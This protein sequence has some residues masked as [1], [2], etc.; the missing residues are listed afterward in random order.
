MSVTSKDQPPSLPL[1]EPSTNTTTPSQTPHSHHTLR[2]EAAAFIGEFIGTFM[3]L[4]LAFTGTQIALNAAGSKELSGSGDPLPDVAKLLYIAFAFGASLAINVAIFADIS[5]G[6]FVTI[7]LY[8]TRKIHWHRATQTII[9][10]LLASIAASAFT[11][12]LLPGPL[13]IATTLSPSISLTRGLF[14][15]ALVTSQLILTILML[16]GGWAKPMY[17]GASL[18]VAHVCSVYYTGASLNPARSFGPAVVGG[19]TGYHWIY[20]V[21]PL[22]GSAV[23]SAVYVGV[24]WLRRERGGV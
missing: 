12:A 7:A 18:F 8:L 10:Q 5:G 16:E 9:S 13:T 20:W 15:E 23:A 17:I 3:F 1:H 22:L 4:S 11:S 19:F 14:L 21:G 24:G 2:T 6:K